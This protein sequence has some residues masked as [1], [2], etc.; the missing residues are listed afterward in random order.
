MIQRIYI[1]SLGICPWIPEIYAD[2]KQHMPKK[3]NNLKP[4]NYKHCIRPPK[5]KNS[6]N[7]VDHVLNTAFSFI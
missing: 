7:M 4:H 1:I 6:P 2:K 5:K 3:N